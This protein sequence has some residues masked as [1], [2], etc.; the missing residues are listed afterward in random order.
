MSCLKNVQ[1][2]FGK[3]SLWD[4]DWHYLEQIKCS[5]RVSEKKVWEWPN[6]PIID[7]ANDFNDQLHMMLLMISDYAV[8]HSNACTRI[9]LLCYLASIE[10]Q[11]CEGESKYS[12]DSKI[13]KTIPNLAFSRSSPA[14]PASASAPPAL[15]APTTP[16]STPVVPPAS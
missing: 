3:V 13:P 7:D 16:A 12:D 10:I 11:K 2:A 15:F 1:L 9:T 6:N 4:Q 14:P 8:F 5:S